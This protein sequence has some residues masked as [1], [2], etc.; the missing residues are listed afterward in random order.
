[1]DIV[2]VQWYFYWFLLLYRQF[3]FI[4]DWNSGSYLSFTRFQRLFVL[5]W[6]GTPT[7]RPKPTLS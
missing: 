1:M 6:T 2:G 3:D 4:A 7:R 5:V